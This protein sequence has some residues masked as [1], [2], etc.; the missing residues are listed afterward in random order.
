MTISVE[1]RSPLALPSQ[2][3]RAP[4][5]DSKTW[6][7]GSVP[8]TPWDISPH[9]TTL[10]G[11]F[12]KQGVR[13]Q[14]LAALSVLRNL[15]NSS[16]Q[17]QPAAIVDGVQHLIADV[18]PAAGVLLSELILILEE[19]GILTPTAHGEPP[20][21]GQPRRASV[22][23]LLQSTLQLLVDDSAILHVWRRERE[24]V[25][26]EMPLTGAPLREEE[27]FVLDAWNMCTSGVVVALRLP[28]TEC[29]PLWSG[30]GRVR[31]RA[32][33]TTRRHR[34]RASLFQEWCHQENPGDSAGG[35][36]HCR[37]QV[38]GTVEGPRL[39]HVWR[40][41]LCCRQAP[42]ESLVTQRDVCVL[43]LV[44]SLFVLLW[45]EGRPHQKGTR[46]VC[47]WPPIPRAEWRGGSVETG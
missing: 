11:L 41:H 44:T 46:H 26:V 14:R 8:W 20:A 38:R 17:P 36:Q 24:A 39:L 30:L 35:H 12:A 47:R 28:T 1:R 7:S 2:F 29:A 33:L 21:D 4:G 19:S 5:L 40:A 27:C 18:D 43:D 10:V 9:V 34:A 31:Q 23:A 6:A 16:R 13:D 25:A 32:R 45:R 37:I 3:S 42:E 15:I 22:R